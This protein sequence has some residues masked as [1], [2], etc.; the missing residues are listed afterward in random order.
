MKRLVVKQQRVYQHCETLPD[1]EGW[2]LSIK[3]VFAASMASLCITSPGS[4]LAK[5]MWVQRAGGVLT[6]LERQAF[7]RWENKGSRIAARVDD[8]DLAGKLV[9]WFKLG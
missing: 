8:V 7:N 6:T 1:Q 9:R 5:I 3:R 2:Q 4:T